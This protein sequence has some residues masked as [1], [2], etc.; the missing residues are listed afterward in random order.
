MDNDLIF[1]EQDFLPAYATDVPYIN[2]AEVKASTDVPSLTNAT[3]AIASTSSAEATVLNAKDIY[4][5][6]D[7]ASLIGTVIDIESCVIE[8]EQNTTPNLLTGHF[9]LENAEIM[10]EDEYVNTEKQNILDQ[11]NQKQVFSPEILRPFPKAK[12][13]L[14][15][16]KSRGRKKRKAAILTDTPEK[17]ELEREAEERKKRAKKF[18]KQ[19]N[20]MCIVCN[21]NI[22][23][24]EKNVLECI[25]CKEKS[26]KKCTN[27]ETD[28]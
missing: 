2:P 22:S 16:T 26:H 11:N 20:L 25:I 17:E 4:P 12:P 7:I 15:E 5:N 13:K 19:E 14:I 8:N 1:S 27:D 18:I 24:K 23:K 3:T 10:F 21:R 28:P 9:D 6:N